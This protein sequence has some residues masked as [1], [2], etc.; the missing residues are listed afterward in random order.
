MAIYFEHELELKSRNIEVF[1]VGSTFPL[2]MKNWF[3][4]DY[5]KKTSTLIIDTILNLSIYE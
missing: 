4:K 3:L 2:K 5:Y 1:Y